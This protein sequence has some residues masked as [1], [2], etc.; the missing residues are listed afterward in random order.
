M[1][2]VLWIV[3]ILTFMTCQMYVVA[4]VYIYAFTHENKSANGSVILVCTD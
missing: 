2:L 1:S 4:K 3:I